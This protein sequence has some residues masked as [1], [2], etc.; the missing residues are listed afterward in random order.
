MTIDVNYWSSFYSSNHTLDA[1]NFCSFVLDF[2]KYQRCL[3]VLDAGCGNGRDTYALSEYY[4]TTGLDTAAYVPKATETCSFE[5][6]D[7]CSYDKST[8]DLIYSRFTLHSIN[9]EQ[10]EQFLSSI[11][12][13]GTYLAIECR[14]DGDVDTVREHGDDHYRNF[15][16]YVRMM[17]LFDSLGF[18]VLFAEEGRGFAPYKTE[19]PVCVRFIVEKA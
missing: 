5:T 15:V 7:F 13:R 9:D 8:F 14:S 3:R 12:K 10:Q 11:T 4:V 16:S 1:S 2:F 17:R 18:I 6:G 19:D